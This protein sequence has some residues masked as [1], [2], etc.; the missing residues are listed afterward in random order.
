MRKYKVVTYYTTYKT[1]YVEA[2]DEES[3]YAAVEPNRWAPYADN[4]ILENLYEQDCIA[5]EV[6]EEDA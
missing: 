6:K 5:V 4:E 1:E 2:L 3:A